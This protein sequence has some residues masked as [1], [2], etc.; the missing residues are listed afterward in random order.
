MSMILADG[1]LAKIHGKVTA[2]IR[3]Q[4]YCCTVTFLTSEM[5]PRFDFILGNDWSQGHGVMADFGHSPSAKPCLQLRCYKVTLYLIQDTFSAGRDSIEDVPLLTAVQAKRAISA[6][7][8]RTCIQP[9][10]L[11]VIRPSKGPLN[12]NRNEIGRDE[13]LNKLLLQFANVF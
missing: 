9:F 2:N 3:I 8:S 12:N 6:R 11:I 10:F 1:T 7:Q 5:L 4:I 13:R